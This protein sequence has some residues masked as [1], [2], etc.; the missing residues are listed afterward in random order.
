M[1]DLEVR[2]IAKSFGDVPAL[3]DVSLRVPDG[4]FTILLGPSGCGK[5][6]LL[7]IIAGLERQKSEPIQLGLRAFRRHL[8]PH[9]KGHP[10][11]IPTFEE[12]VVNLSYF[13]PNTGQWLLAV[14][15]NCG[16]SANPD[17]FC[18]PSKGVPMGCPNPA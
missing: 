1:A 7:R 18:N 17:P 9:P 14:A 10:S 5:S 15:G 13:D 2:S 4:G 8:T 16:E 11:Y 3:A 6:T 12:D